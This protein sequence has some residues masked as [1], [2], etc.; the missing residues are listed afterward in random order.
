[1]EQ[2][3]GLNI[4]EKPITSEEEYQ[5]ERQALIAR[6]KEVAEEPR[7]SGNDGQLLT[8]AFIGFG[9]LEARKAEGMPPPPIPKTP[10]ETLK[11]VLTAVNKSVNQ[12]LIDL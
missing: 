12:A 8:Q 10:L 7:N 6:L 2:Q 11:S 5:A 1:M 9:K 3:E 4:I